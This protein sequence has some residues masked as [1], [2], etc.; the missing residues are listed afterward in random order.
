MEQDSLIKYSFTC[1]PGGIAFLSTEGYFIR[2]NPAFVRLL[3]YTEDELANRQEKQ[4]TYPNDPDVMEAAAP[5]LE[6]GA[7]PG[8]TV[9]KRYL[10][11][12]GGTVRVKLDVTLIH[13]QDGAHAGFCAYAWCGRTSCA[14]HE[15]QLECRIVLGN[16][17]IKFIRIQ[18]ITTLTSKGRP[19]RINGTYGPEA[20]AANA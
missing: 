2:V 14:G 16:G 7:A 13:D 4:L 1:A 6:P 12:D 3:G 18:S 5:L 15:I 8:M 11:K 9:V 17:T 20:D 19:S 10:H